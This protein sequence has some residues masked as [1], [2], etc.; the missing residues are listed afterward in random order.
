MTDINCDMGEGIGNEVLLMPFINSANIAC[1]YHAG[2][3]AT[4][5]STVRLCLEYQVHIG[6]HPSF[7]DRENF[8]RTAI[9]LPV[10]E[11]YE[12]VMVQL[13]ILQKI[14]REEGASLHHVKPH[15]A[16]YNMAAKDRDIAKAI[17]A[18]VKDF[19]ASLVY[20]GASGSVMIE[21]AAEQGL[22]VAN[23]VFAD[24]TYQADGSLTDRSHP[25]AVLLKV[26]DVIEQVTKLAKENK[27]ITAAGDE[28][29]LKAD[30]ICLHGDGLHAPEFAK[31]IKDALSKDQIIYHQGVKASPLEKFGGT[32]NED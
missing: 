26:D 8:G 10:N 31:A 21:E 23:E 28:L 32:V 25:R 18:A 6:A 22:A 11:I 1:G 7:Y 20:Y 17:A 9:Q 13:N 2:D 19:N 24:R 4:M 29:F 16:L 30:T 27:V 12:L 14:V 15:G 3:E 5:R